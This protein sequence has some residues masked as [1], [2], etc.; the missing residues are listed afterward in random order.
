MWVINGQL[1]AFDAVSL[2]LLYTTGQ[3]LNG[4][5]TLPAVGH[6]VTQTVANGRVYVGTRNSLEAYGLFHVVS[7]T[8]GNAQTAT[9]AT[10]LSTPLRVHAANPYTGQ[11]DVGAAVNFSDG[12]KPGT[13]ACGSF[14]TNPAITDSNGNASTTYTLPKKAG[15]YTVTISGNGFGPTTATATAKPAAPV[16]IIAYAGEP[17]NPPRG[18]HLAHPSTTPPQRIIP[19]YYPRTT[20]FLPTIQV[21]PSHPHS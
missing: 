2:K 11:P 9:V 15:T 19:P 5:D 17:L 14:S 1:S 21:P 7:L 12:C 8:G 13:T 18:F 3:A 10:T 16:K 20:L 6:F 4:R